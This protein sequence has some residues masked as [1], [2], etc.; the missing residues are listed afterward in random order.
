MD[1]LNYR[2]NDP[3]KLSMALTGKQ[4]NTS[5][6]LRAFSTAIFHFVTII[7]NTHCVLAKQERLSRDKRNELQILASNITR[8]SVHIDFDLI[9]N[10]IQ[11]L[12]PMLGWVNPYSIWE[13]TVQ[14]YNFLKTIGE[15][16]RQ[17]LKPSIQ[18]TDSPGAINIKGVFKE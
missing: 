2:Y 18:V 5:F 13:Y 12:A 15:K 16:N 6:D 9:M 4:T 7:D 8:G 3:V 10:G 17:G 11:I 14:S 1:E